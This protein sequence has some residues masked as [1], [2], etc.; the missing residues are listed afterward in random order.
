MNIFI[1]SIS[2]LSLLLI[3]HELGHLAMAKSS[4]M[5]VEEFAIGL[6]P[7]VFSRKFGETLYSIR[8]IPL[9]GFNQISG[10]DKGDESG[11]RSFQSKSYLSRVLVIASGSAMNFI[12]A[13][14]FLFLSNIMSD[15]SFLKSVLGAIQQFLFFINMI[16]SN[17]VQMFI[18]KATA[19]ATGPLGMINVTSQVMVMGPIVLLKFMG[20][21][22]V[23]LG[24]FNLLPIPCL[25]GGQIVMLVIEAVRGKPLKQKLLDGLQYCG[26]A[27]I[28]MAMI[29][30]TGKDILKILNY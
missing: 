23:N 2:I 28:G 8:M 5:L 16:I 25:D 17:V 7:K 1:M 21:L 10:M 22:S 14:A 26:M 24:I 12:A 9:G 6:G 20:I 3:F 18:G 27:V 29:W 15:V 19:D 30:T 13:I 4:D 11:A